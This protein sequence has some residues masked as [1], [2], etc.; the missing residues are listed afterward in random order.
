MS[1]MTPR[2]VSVERV[3]E[4]VTL[5]MAVLVTWYVGQ[6]T[7]LIIFPGPLLQMIVALNQKYQVEYTRI[8]RAIIS[9][10][11]VEEGHKILKSAD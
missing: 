11:S 5:M 8:S 9:L 1:L 6:T 10:T 7:A 3:K 4:T 2:K